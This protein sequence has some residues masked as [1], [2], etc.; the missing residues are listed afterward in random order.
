MPSPNQAFV[1]TAPGPAAISVVRIT[2]EG[3]VPFLQQHLSSTAGSRTMVCTHAN[4]HDGD[5]V[6]DDPVVVVHEDAL[7][8]DLSL[9]GGPWVVKRCLQ[10]LAKHGFVVHDRLATPLPPATVDADDAIEQAILQL[11]PLARTE[12]AV[13]ALLKQIPAWQNLSTSNPSLNQLHQI[14]AD[15]ALINLLRLPR[16]AIIGPPNVGKSTLANQL[17]AQQRSITADLPGTT[18]DW[19]GA[20][21]DIGGLAVMLIDTPG[22]RR[23]DDTIEHAAIQI[24]RQQISAA[25]LVLIVIDPDTTVDQ[26]QQLLNQHPAA[27]VIHNKSDLA[28]SCSN[29]A[30]QHHPQHQ[31][32]AT[33]ATTGHGLDQLRVAIKQHFGCA[34]LN[35]DQPRPWS[36]EHAQHLLNLTTSTPGSASIMP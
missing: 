28:G 17:F 25:D 4:L 2:G 34:N 35:L 31:V 18:R 7:T 22:Q 10:L 5:E 9:H 26:T 21:A 14:A 1:L 29:P 13:R 12:L 23:T 24:S 20:I 30:E 3:V 16:L 11:L 27:I 33:V 32:L 36:I 15:S 8:A 19:V 6:I